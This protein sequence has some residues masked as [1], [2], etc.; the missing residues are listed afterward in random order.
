MRHPGGEGAFSLPPRCLP[1]ISSRLVS[2]ELQDVCSQVS[3]LET[4]V[5]LKDSKIAAL[6][7]K[8]QASGLS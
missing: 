8:L 6:T 3:K 4:L 1:R 5:R 2:S 7:A